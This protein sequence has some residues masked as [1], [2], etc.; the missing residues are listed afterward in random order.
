MS[1]EEYK[2]KNIITSES[3]DGQANN[4]PPA[5]QKGMFGF[6]TNWFMPKK[7]IIPKNSEI[8]DENNDFTTYIRCIFHD[9]RGPLNNISL[10]IE[11]LL[12]SIT[13]DT[14]EFTTA[15]S[16]KESCSFLSESLDGFLNVNNLN[17]SK[18][19]ELKL[20]YQ[21]F[22]II[23]LIKKIQYILMSSIMNK[24][25]EIKY[26]ILPVHE[27]VM[28]DSKHIQHVLMNLLSN[29]IKFSIIKSSIEIKLEGNQLETSK[30]H[31]A[32]SIIDENQFIPENIR[33]KLFK[34]YNTSNNKEGTGLGL[35][36][37]KKIVETH[38]G[39][40]NHFYKSN[41]DH[42]NIFKVELFLD[43]CASSDNQQKILEDSRRSKHMMFQSLKKRLKRT[44]SSIHISKRN[45]SKH[46]E[47]NE[48]K[49][50][51]KMLLHNI[52]IEHNEE[53]NEHYKVKIMVVDDSDLSRKFMIRLF[54]QNCLEYKLYDAIDGL[55]A[56]IKMIKFNETGNKINMLLVD[57]IMPNMNG[58]LL[59]KILRGI[60]Y[61]GIIVG[62][63]GNGMT[64]DRQQYLENGADL[65]F[66]KPFT[67]DKLMALIQFVKK[68]G[69]ESKMDRKIVEIRGV[70]EWT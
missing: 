61:Q 3:N 22:N 17:N 12:D 57:N 7:R 62:I 4:S 25:L 14:E 55:D 32:I 48:I 65:I 18:I 33:N 37:C 29:A 64:K 52:N 21:P 47:N 40:I 68:E 35:Y 38:G 11:I 26:N 27:W 6:I 36:I 44:V 31:V 67:K 49:K 1:S 23:G 42:G 8:Q 28:G 13:K 10:G 50:N 9:F 30:Q 56:L 19:V 59:C 70:L 41:S 34:K 66:V 39:I 45:Y 51:T 58:E 24:K 5:F 2:Y 54:Q 43:V 63:T 46:D 16:I 15:E 69:Y 53:E 60:G 20:I